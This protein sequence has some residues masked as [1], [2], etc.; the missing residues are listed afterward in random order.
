MIEYPKPLRKG[1]TIGI[2]APSSGVTG[3]F[4]KKL[5]FAKKQLENL[6]YKTIE[7]PYVK[8]QEKLT[9]ASA[10]ERAISFEKMY[11]DDSIK[12]IIPPWGGEFL[13]D[14]L[15]YLNFDELRKAPGKWIMG[16][17][18]IS[19]LL[20]VLTLNINIATAH[21]PNLLDFGNTKIDSSV[22]R[23]LELLSKKE[24]EIFK[25]KSLNYYQKE[26]L[27]VTMDNFPPYQLTEKVRWKI[28]ESKEAVQF[29]GRLIGGNLDVICKLIGTKYDHVREFI[30]DNRNDGII[31]YFESCEINSTDLYRSLW[32]MQMNGWFKNC[33]GVVFGRADGYR[34]VR[35][36]KLED[37][38]KR[39]F[40][41]LRIPVVYD[42]DLG[43][44]PPQLVF[45]NGA[46]GEVTVNNGQGEIIQKLI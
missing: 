18:D 2:V 19:T 28:L 6:G 29:K 4:A 12:A 37:A 35:D 30:E 7:D 24:N 33:N 23:S 10:K 40:M 15:P 46:Y 21:G 26:W 27:E 42:I 39:A 1:D 14:M 41:D 44:L 22:L 32:Q 45:I 17:S 25:Q 43:H 16:F 3:V 31:W 8:N 36:F 34:D 38:Y 13:M 11:F 9:S 5:D 20:F